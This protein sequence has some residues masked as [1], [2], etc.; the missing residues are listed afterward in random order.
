MA[1]LFWWTVLWSVQQKCYEGDKNFFK[2]T[3]VSCHTDYH[4]LVT[5]VIDT[6]SW[7]QYIFFQVTV[8]MESMHK[9]WPEEKIHHCK[10][11]STFSHQFCSCTHC[12]KTC[13]V[14]VLPVHNKP[15]T[16][17]GSSLLLNSCFRGKTLKIR[18][19]HSD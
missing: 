15:A 12:R 18:S 9:L 17:V 6:F 4:K 5:K 16:D 10:P 8:L 11:N 14:Q 19:D 3:L 1:L 13:L 2:R 7:P